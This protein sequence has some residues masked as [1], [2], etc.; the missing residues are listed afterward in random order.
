MPI[1]PDRVGDPFLG[2]CSW[3]A[4]PALAPWPGQ[5]CLLTSAFSPPPPR[6]ERYRSGRS[7]Q[8]AS[9]GVSVPPGEGAS[10]AG[11]PTSHLWVA[12][13]QTLAAA[14][15]ERSVTAALRAEVARALTGVRGGLSRVPR[16][17]AWILSS[18]A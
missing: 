8:K 4:C 10:V 14:V 18:R 16:A 11:H 15:D 13:A 17:P 2:L 12:A 3:E 1:L 5:P 9:N 6:F 7:V